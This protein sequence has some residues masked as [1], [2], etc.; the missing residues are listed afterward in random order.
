MSRNSEHL[1]SVYNSKEMPLKECKTNQSGVEG[2]AEDE[3]EGGDI[4]SRINP[5][6][7]G[8]GNMFLISGLRPTNV[9]YI[10]IF[11]VDFFGNKGLI[12]LRYEM[13]IMTFNLLFKFQI[14]SS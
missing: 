14:Y 6:P 11:K 5:I 4:F 2:W 3:R 7:F 9:F 12:E 10:S 1:S 8:G 13:D